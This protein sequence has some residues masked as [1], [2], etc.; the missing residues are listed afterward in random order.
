MFSSKATFSSKAR[1]KAKNYKVPYTREAYRMFKEELLEMEPAE[2]MVCVQILFQEKNNEVVH[3]R[4]VT[5]IINNVDIV[6]HVEM[7]IASEVV[8]N[9][10]F[11]LI[12]KRRRK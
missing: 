6:V 1:K 9:T 8:V 12:K 11:E 5:R 10:L 4:W 7:P 2:A 3:P